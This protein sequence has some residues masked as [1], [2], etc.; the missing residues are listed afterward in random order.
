LEIQTAAR[1]RTQDPTAQRV[2]QR[3]A[4]SLASTA[5]RNRPSEITEH[6]PLTSISNSPNSTHSEHTMCPPIGQNIGGPSGASTSA[7][8]DTD[9]STN[10]N[11]PAAMATRKMPKPGEKNAP[12]FDPEKPEELGRFFERM[13]DWFADENI[14]SDVDK[15]RRIVRYL[16]PDSEGQWKALPEFSTGT[17]EE[18][19]LQVMSSYPAAEEVLKG[20]VTALKRKI[21][22]LGPIAVDERD[23]LLTL[24]RVMT[25]EI[26]KL[27]NISPPIHTNRELVELFLARLTPDF[28]TRISE[29]LSVNGLIGANNQ[30]EDAEVRN[31]EDMY[32]VAEV[33]NMAK[34]TSLEHANPFGKYLWR[35][36]E[37]T[38]NVK[39]EEAV[40]RLT[41][42]ITAQTQYTKTIEQRLVSM[43]H[44]M[45]QSRAQ[46][47]AP[48]PNY[49]RNLVPTSNHVTPYNGGP[50]FYCN[51]PHRVANCEDVFRHLDL[52]WI[53]RID[54]LLKW[55]DGMRILREIGKTMKEVVEGRNKSVPG[56]IPVSKI[57]DK[58]SLY[59]EVP[60]ASNY[61]QN[62][63]TAPTDDDAS[64]TLFELVQQWGADK[65]QKL[66]N[67]E[68]ITEEGEP[69][70]QNFDRVQ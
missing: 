68:S 61:I 4:A 42:S 39:L 59:Q 14:R 28:A 18:F 38:N 55:P 8:V 26:V 45:N 63:S 10:P 57:Q 34:R 50:C 32:D 64:R 35:S 36:H 48:P 21:K 25:A 15:K 22:K 17:F 30:G 24:I 7:V 54:G 70:D 51:G 19:K 3:I 12:A 52:G 53:K 41:D 67:R 27:K 11:I 49:N 29:K 20:S 33:M 58:T 16:D 23:E 1:V 6:S 37:A 47:Q 62:Q 5:E 43:Q 13:A 46:P 60:S 31:A 56:I 2:E 66:L 9:P 65:I 44:N 40:A 69:Y